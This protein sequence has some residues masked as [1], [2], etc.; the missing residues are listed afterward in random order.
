MM[1][2]VTDTASWTHR[3]FVDEVAEGEGAEDLPATLRG[4]SWAVQSAFLAPE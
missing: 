1:G 3:R 4:A 2:N